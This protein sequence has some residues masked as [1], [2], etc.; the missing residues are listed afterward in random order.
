[1]ETLK[2]RFVIA[3]LLLSFFSCTKIEPIEIDGIW[4]FDDE[5]L[6]HF[7]EGSAF[8][9]SF[10]PSG[11]YFFKNDTLTLENVYLR[12]ED[13]SS[14]DLPPIDDHNYLKFLMTS[15]DDMFISLLPIGDSWFHDAH[16][17]EF[18]LKR[19][20]V[21]KHSIGSGLEISLKIKKCEDSCLIFLISGS[22]QLGYEVFDVRRNSEHRIK[23]NNQTSINFLINNVFEKNESIKLDPTQIGGGYYFELI[24]KEQNLLKKYEF[25]SNYPLSS[26]LRLLVTLLIYDSDF[27]LIVLD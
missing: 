4:E 12:L 14:F 23:F 16:S 1:M 20:Q 19:I 27:K 25:N 11:S 6:W 24:L 2:K 7:S 8:Y 3:C 5:L 22:E 17:Q 21:P 10:L 15:Y 26:S 18:K 9:Q 13:S